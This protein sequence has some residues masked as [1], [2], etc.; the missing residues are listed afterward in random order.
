MAG[1]GEAS[2]II[3]TIHIGFSLAR[4]LIAVVGDYKSAREDINIVATEI[5]ATLKQAAELDTLVSNNTRTRRLNDNGLQLAEK[6]KVDLTRIV[7]KL[8]GELTKAKIPKDQTYTIQPEDI[9]VG[10]FTR[11]AWVFLKP[12]V[13]VIQHELN[14]VRLQILLAHTCIDAESA[15]KASD[16]AAASKLIPGLR[17][18]RAMARQMVRKAQNESDKAEESAMSNRGIEVQS[19]PFESGISI[20]PARR[21][22]DA[23]RRSRYASS[24]STAGLP[25][26]SPYGSA[27]DESDTDRLAEEIRRE[28]E[29]ELLAKLEQQVEE[30]EAKKAY[31]QRMRDEAVEGYKKDTRDRLSVIKER[32][33]ETQRRLLAAFTS[34]LPAT[35][36]QDFL[37]AQH[38][39]E[40]NDEFVQLMIDSYKAPSLSHNSVK[41][42]DTLSQR[43]G[44][45][46]GSTKR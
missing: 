36:I 24:R 30:Q 5:D 25:A 20:P 12:R 13:K 14:N 41:D 26:Q 8:I 44:S 11:T 33:A 28:L 42:V 37:D 17:Q 31:E 3:G 39:Q 45:S 10:K 23:T 46:H 16:R 29:Q 9:E 34:E 19:A 4:T 2:A 27:L 43:T 35:E 32:S 22:L 6:C 15:P 18:S 40:L 1:V 38:S 21:R 7:E